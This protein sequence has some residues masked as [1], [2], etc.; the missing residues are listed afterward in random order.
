MHSVTSILLIVR[1]ELGRR[2][3]RPTGLPVDSML[4]LPD[5]ALP[6]QPAAQPM[7]PVSHLRVVRRSRPLLPCSR[8][9]GSIGCNFEACRTF[10]A[11]RGQPR[12]GPHHGTH[13]RISHHS[14]VHTGLLHRTGTRHTHGRRANS[15]RSSGPSSAFP[16]LAPRTLDGPS[17]YLVIL[18]VADCLCGVLMCI[19]FNKGEAAIGLHSDLDNVA[20]A[21]TRGQRLSHGVWANSPGIT[22]TGLPEWNTE[23]S[24]RHRPSCCTLESAR[25]P[26]RSPGRP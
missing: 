12:S 21:L 5:L 14:H 22:D 26:S 3:R 23:S 4:P 8:I 6:I 17:V 10:V 11:A 13:H 24:C 1:P 15:S 7:H 16:I 9:P 2:S 20:V 18:Q 19:E 25:R